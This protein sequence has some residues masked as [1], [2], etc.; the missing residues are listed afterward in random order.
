[1]KQSFAIADESNG[2]RNQALILTS[3]V[4][5]VF[6]A[7]LI[8]WRLARPA[9]STPPLKVSISFASYTNDAAGRRLGTFA[10]TNQSDVELL[11][12]RYC[13]IEGRIENSFS[14]NH[15]IREHLLAPSGS[16][17]VAVVSPT[18]LST[19]RVTFYFSQ[20]RQW[21]K[22]RALPKLYRALPEEYR[23]F[24]AQCYASSEWVDQ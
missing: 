4:I 19:W 10:L 2:M 23:T 5:V 1:L 24:R 15:H 12:F 17:L 6:A 21:R 9:Q 8:I 18:N 22:L 3:V 13:S 16:E 14:S 7:A 20:V 11:R